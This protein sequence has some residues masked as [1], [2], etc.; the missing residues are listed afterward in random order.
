MR[1][2][3]VPKDGQVSKRLSKM[4]PR[5]RVESGDPHWPQIEDY[6][7]IG[8][9]GNVV[10]AGIPPRMASEQQRSQPKPATRAPGFMALNYGVKSPISVFL[11]HAAFGAI[12]GSLYHLSQAVA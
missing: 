10:D 6:G 2:F 4:N 12:L 3:E 5:K 1:P 11:A 8:E 7:I 9:R